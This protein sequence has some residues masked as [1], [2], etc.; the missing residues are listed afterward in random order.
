MRTIYTY[1][2]NSNTGQLIKEQR[3]EDISFVC[4]VFQYDCNGKQIN[5]VDLAGFVRISEQKFIREC[6]YKKAN[7]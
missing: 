1:Y 2:K 3:F 6:R 5:P 7:P 4:P